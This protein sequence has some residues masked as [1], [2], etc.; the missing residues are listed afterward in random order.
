MGDA[1][2]ADAS[3]ATYKGLAIALTDASTKTMWCAQHVAICLGTLYDDRDAAKGDM[4]G[5]ANTDALIAHGTHTHAAASAARNYNSGTHPARTSAW[6]LPSTGQ[7]DKM[8]TAAGGFAILRDNA[9]LQADSYWSSTEQHNSLN[10]NAFSYDFS[11][12]KWDITS[13]G[14]YF[15]VRSALAF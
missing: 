14:S 2:T 13:K 5:I 15:I 7:W 9:S 12:G 10:M 8:I 6:F 11:Y 4:A 1:G 3:S